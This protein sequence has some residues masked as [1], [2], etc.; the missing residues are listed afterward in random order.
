MQ[1]LTATLNFL[2]CTIVPGCAFTRGMYDRLTLKNKQGLPLKQHHHVLL[3]TEFVTDCRTWLKFLSDPNNE[4][5][6]CKF[7][8]LSSLGLA[9][10]HVLW[11]YTDASQNEKFRM[12]AVY[13]D[14]H[15]IQ[16]RWPANFIKQC[17]SSIEFL[18]LFA[19]TAA[20]VT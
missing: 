8:D 17:E 11:F 20:V 13:D 4:K 1:Q 2:N 14:R 12:G 10:A 18:E 5:L 7:V 9:N 16:Y 6:C 15:W 19:L 3:N